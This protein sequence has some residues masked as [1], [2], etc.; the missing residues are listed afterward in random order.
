[1]TLYVLSA[2]PGMFCMGLWSLSARLTDSGATPSQSV[3]VSASNKVFAFFLSFF[4]RHRLLIKCD[5]IFGLETF[6]FPGIPFNVVLL[7]N[8]VFLWNQKKHRKERKLSG[9]RNSLDY[10]INFLNHK[11]HGGSGGYLLLMLFSLSL[12]VSSALGLALVSGTYTW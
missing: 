6:L 12:S 7:F 5:L 10:F 9:R 4:L 2:I 3:E 8:V 1:M 11:A